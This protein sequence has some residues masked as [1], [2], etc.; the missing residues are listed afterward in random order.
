MIK[1][2]SIKSNVLGNWKF[3]ELKYDTFMRGVGQKGPCIHARNIGIYFKY[4]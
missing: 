4:I 1:Y 2:Y 3:A